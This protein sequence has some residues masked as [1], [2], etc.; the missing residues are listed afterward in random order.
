M[1]DFKQGKVIEIIEKRDSLSEIKVELQGEEA[2]AINY[3][4]LTG[5]IAVGDE[6][7]LNT[8]AVDL[9][10]GSGGEHFVSWNLKRHSLSQRA[11]GHIVKLRYTPMQMAVLSAEEEES[12]LHRDLSVVTNLECTPVVIGT[13]HSQLPAVVASAK[14]ITPQAKIT[15][16]MTDGGALPINFS[17]L[18]HRLKEL[19]LIES[20]ITCGQAFGGEEEAINI[21]SALQVAKVQEA[22]IIVV[23]MGP[24]VVGTGT[25]LGFSAIEQ[26]QIINAVAS[27]NGVSVAIPR[28][29][30]KD[31]RPRHF[32]ISHHTITSLS[33][34]ALASAIVPLPQLSD[35]KMKIVKDKLQAAE[36]EKKHQ[37]EVIESDSVLKILKKHN[38]KVT[39]M[40]RSIDEEPEFFKAAGAAGIYAAETLK[41]D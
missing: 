18:V 40:G 17:K 32:G 3:D 14:E 4:N 16:I 5:E 28:L 37:I 23:I 41:G 1:I 24:G 6:V 12:P 9:N 2:R 36:I 25:A 21:Y 30:F 8:T 10:L 39:T 22:D 19:K 31:E 13:L 20:T 29:S 33:V 15:Y 27:L 34:A 7:V 38:L 26:G 11:K 35:D